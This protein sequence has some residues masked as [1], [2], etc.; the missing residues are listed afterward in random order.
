MH[1]MQNDC[2][3]DVVPLVLA[4]AGPQKIVTIGSINHF[5]RHVIEQEATWRQLCE[6]LYKVR[7]IVIAVVH[8]PLAFLS[9][10]PLESPHHLYDFYSSF[11]LVKKVERRR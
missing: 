1:W 5:W 10:H 6:S 11:I 4:F 9:S 2:P 3:K 8:F 7:W